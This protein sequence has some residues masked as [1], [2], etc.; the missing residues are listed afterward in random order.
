[1]GPRAAE[2]LS[3][4]SHNQQPQLSQPLLHL[5]VV[6]YPMIEQFDSDAILKNNMHLPLF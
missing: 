1:M 3:L 4:E 5:Q 6:L 2:I